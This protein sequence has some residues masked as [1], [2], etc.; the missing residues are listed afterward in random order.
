MLGSDGEGASTYM[1]LARAVPD[2]ACSIGQEETAGHDQPER[3]SKA[4]QRRW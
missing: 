3:P 1:L 4:G 2:S